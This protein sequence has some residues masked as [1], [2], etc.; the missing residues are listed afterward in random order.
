MSKLLSRPSPPL[1]RLLGE[2]VINDS[3]MEFFF[4]TFFLYLDLV[5]GPKVRIICANVN[6]YSR[7]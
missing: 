7:G 4:L 6:G 5:Y 2:T 1:Y 3:Q